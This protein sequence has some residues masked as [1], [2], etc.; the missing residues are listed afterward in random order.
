MEDWHLNP[1]ASETSIQEAIS[2]LGVALPSDYLSF[3]RSSNGGEGFIG[4]HYLI[5]WRIEELKPFNTDYEVEQYA[6]GILLFGSN[7]GGEGLGFDLRDP[8]MPVVVMPFIGMDLEFVIPAAATFTH[9]LQGDW[10][11]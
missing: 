9:L 8:G 1:G 6:P 10:P 5:L 7:G 4:E 11:L 2:E 3:M